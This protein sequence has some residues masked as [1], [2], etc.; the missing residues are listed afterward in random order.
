MSIKINLSAH[1]FFQATA[2][3][4]FIGRRVLHF[5]ISF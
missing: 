1:S 4:V 3:V 5:P 2:F